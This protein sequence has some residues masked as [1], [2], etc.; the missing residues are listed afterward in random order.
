MSRILN[1]KILLKYN[2]IAFILSLFFIITFNYVYNI[3]NFN[4]NFRSMF[5]FYLVMSELIFFIIDNIV[6]KIY[7]INSNDIFIKFYITNR[8]FIFILSFLIFT[9]T[10]DILNIFNL[11]LFLILGFIITIFSN[12]FGRYLSFKNEIVTSNKINS[13]YCYTFSIQ[14]LF[15]TILYMIFI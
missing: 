2:F 7:K 4:I 11:L 12:Y 1:Y 10:I 9:L 6:K 15:L 3:Y 14:L 13:Y 8:Y 5:S